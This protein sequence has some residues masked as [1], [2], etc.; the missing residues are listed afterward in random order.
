VTDDDQM[1]MREQERQ[2]ALVDRVLGLEAQLAEL[3][4]ASSLSAGQQLAAEKEL[5]RIR[6]SAEWRIARALTAPA[7]V[8]RRSLGRRAR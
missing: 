5:A 7:R 2:L 8:A 3:T 4:V 6:S 1:R